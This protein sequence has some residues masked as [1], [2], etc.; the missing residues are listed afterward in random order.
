MR[1]PA[2]A[3]A[4]RPLSSATR[5]RATAAQPRSAG[6]IR[7]SPWHE[8]WVCAVLAALLLS[9]VAWL[10]LHYLLASADD[11]SPHPAEAWSLRLHGA[12]AM[13]TLLLVGGLLT[14]HSLPAWRRGLNRASGAWLAGT[15]LL[16]TVTGYLLYYAGA[17]AVRDNASW[18][19]WV[20]GLGV[21]LLLGLHMWKAG[22]W[23][24]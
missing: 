2:R 7:L 10:V 21:P 15:M 5:A 22:R 3:D 13:A 9:G 8:A 24:R 23:R 18:L 14:Q 20:A 19:H 16:L 6:S 4:A 17:P 12:L 1:K 11:L